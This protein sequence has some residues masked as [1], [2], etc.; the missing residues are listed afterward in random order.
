[1]GIPFYIGM[2]A[3]FILIYIFNWVV[4]MMIMVSI[5]RKNCQQSSPKGS[6]ENPNSTISSRQQFII[7]IV[8]SVLFGLGWGI[9]LLATEKINNTSVRDMFASLFIIITSFHGLLIFIFHCARSKDAREEWLKWF[10]KATKRDLS[11]LTSSVF[12]HVY[13]HRNPNSSQPPF[14]PTTCKAIKM[15]HLP[16]SFASRP[17][18]ATNDP[19]TL[20][21]VS[22]NDYELESVVDQHT[23]QEHHCDKAMEAEK[24]ME[25]ERAM[26]AEMETEITKVDLAEVKPKQA[27]ASMPDSNATS[28]NQDNHIFREDPAAVIVHVPD[29]GNDEPRDRFV[30]THYASV[31][32]AEKIKSNPPQS[33]ASYGKQT[34]KDAD[35]EKKQELCLASL[36]EDEKGARKDADQPRGVFDEDETPSEEVKPN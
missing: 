23:M 1:M 4:F 15:T 16:P 17:F 2:I 20:K 11:D 9:G 14:Q 25:T 5:I 22:M 24:A 21:V 3:P 13:R 10:F 6:V 28:S 30:S 7:A 27:I 33:T 8:L 32:A 31:T 36:D 34:P 19:G 18:S 35:K 12:D 29:D 26:E